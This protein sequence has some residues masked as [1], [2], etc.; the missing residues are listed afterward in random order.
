M[1]KGIIFDLDG[2]TINTLNELY[3]SINQTLKDYNYPTKTLD[4]VRLSVG[5]GFRRLVEDLVP[6]KL[7]EEKIATIGQSY[8]EIYTKHY[9]NSKVYPGMVELLKGLQERG[10]LLAVNSNKSDRFTKSLILNNYPEID[11]TAI[12]GGRP[13]VPN[14][15][16]PCTANQILEEMGLSKEEVLYVGDSE[17]DIRTGKNAGL[18]TVGVLWGFRD[19]ETLLKAGAD[20]IL[21]S[22]DDLL[23]LI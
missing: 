6:E 8:Q 4:E 13:D 22:P 18:Q 12:Y 10:I 9:L 19:R 2:T 11:F 23:K 1:I 15:P 20:H 14:K 3:V 17:V 21:E 16:D 5:R 7:E